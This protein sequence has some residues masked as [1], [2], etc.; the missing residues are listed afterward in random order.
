M[1]EG[2]GRH[3]MISEIMGINTAG[4]ISVL[5]ASGEDRVGGI[6]DEGSLYSNP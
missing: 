6:S 5:L 1:E 4:A 2:G 3:A